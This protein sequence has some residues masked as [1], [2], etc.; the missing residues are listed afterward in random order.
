MSGHFTSLLAAA[1]HEESGERVPVTVLTGFLGSGKT[2]LLNRLLKLPDL[3]GTA[4]IV[5]EFGT[6]GIDQDLI[7]Q[8]S[9]DTI[10][11]PNG[12]LCCA[13]R[14]DLVEALTR[15]SEQDEIAGA[16]LRQV[17][18]ETS[19]LADPGPILRTLMGDPAVR[20]RFAVAGVA[21]TVD[22]VLGMGTLDAHPESVQQVAVADA[23]L[24]TKLDLLDGPPAPA[25]LERLQSL[26]ANATLHLDRERLPVALRDLMQRQDALSAAAA[27]ADARA[28]TPFYRPV[29]PA[30]PTDQA[31][32]H[33]D[34][35]ASFVLVRDEPLPREAF[36]A[37]M[38]LI[39]ASRGEDLLRVKGLVHLAEQPEQPLVIHGVQHLFHPPMSLPAWPGT[40]RRTRIVFIT[41]GL[42]AEALGQT[43]DVLVRRHMRSRRS[44]P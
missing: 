1:A 15:L 42:D 35:I 29:N 5:N 8:A 44:A 9:D 39:V 16:P 28:E 11:L 10:L 43:L 22:A 4:V 18:I 41:R 25:L 34:G 14:G 12:C 33:R 3:Q 21:C 7:A 31:P 32:R 26:N 13:L 37:W 36:F 6:V 40:D 2:T 27:Q 23:L 38:D 20:P 19:G 17:L 30:I 24:L